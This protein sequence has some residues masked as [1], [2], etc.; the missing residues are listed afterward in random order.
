MGYTRKVFISRP[1]QVVAVGI[2]GDRPASVSF[3]AYL[4]R[5][6]G[7]HRG[8]N[9]HVD[10]ITL[11][12]GGVQLHGNTGGK[13]G[14]N[15]IGDMRIVV[16]GG[17]RERIGEHLFVRNAD[18]A[19]ILIGGAGDFYHDDPRA[20]LDE[21]MGR[22][23]CRSFEALQTEH[24]ADY[25]PLFNRVALQ[26][27]TPPSER[28]TDVRLE[29]MRQGSCDEGFAE[30]Y[31]NFGR[32]L[33]ISSSRPGTLPANLQGIW[34]NSFTPPWDS[35]YTININAQMNYWPA[36]VCGLGE[37]HQPLFDL[38]E[39]MVPHGQR[40]ARTMYG[41]RGFVAHHNTDLTA[42][43]A[44]Q[45]VFL[46]GT[47]WVMGAA[48][49][50]LHLWEH[51]A[52]SQDKAFLARALPTLKEACLFFV[53]H[54]IENEAGHLV[55]SPS[56]SPENSYIHPN[57]QVGAICEGTTMDA[58]IISALYEA[59]LR[60]ADIV[61]DSED[62]LYPAM[63]DVL[64]KLPTMRIGRHGQLMEWL[65]DYTEQEVGHRHMSH[66]WGLFPG[67]AITPEGTPELA[68]AARVTVQRRLDG[69]G[70][71][72]SGWERAWAVLC[73]ARL[74]DGAAVGEHLHEMFTGSTYAGLLNAYPP[75]QI[76]GN[77]GATA[78]I[79]EALLQSYEMLDGGGWGI[80]ILPALPPSWAN[81]SVRGL[82][83]R[84]GLTVDIAWRDGKC[85][86]ATLTASS[87][88]RGT[89]TIEGR[90]FP[91]ALVAG[92]SMTMDAE[93]GGV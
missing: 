55:V 28:P 27:E 91:V 71:P 26:L 67:W 49:L 47:Y 7:V 79:A 6:G 40:T 70:R 36:E 64:E 2:S 50:S 1:A 68:E 69:G 82:R 5:T 80:R 54:L 88:F 8:Q 58:Q 25:Q 44:P 41:C 87:D 72:Y 56:V 85:A 29:A 45:G 3:S 77:F 13:A 90:C 37:C 19:M 51:Y 43:T 75:F 93:G 4:N 53:D 61:G 65:E 89:V 60:A 22:A 31:F 48:W 18:R 83:A 46:P 20:W 21:V 34:N 10:A 39:R 84:G 9:R 30:L 57:G 23:V 24:L 12:H 11:D 62:E 74:R 15:F 92:E 33:L 52:F 78:A 42:D 35:K 63:R 86:E 32:Y 73:Y 76:D 66:L 16:E 14:V 17:Q 81:G 38:I 59:T